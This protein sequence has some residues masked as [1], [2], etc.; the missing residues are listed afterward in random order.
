MLFYDGSE[1]EGR[2]HFKRLFDIGTHCVGLERGW[3]TDLTRQQGLHLIVRRQP[4]MTRSMGSWC[5]EWSFSPLSLLMHILRPKSSLLADATTK[6]RSHA[7]SPQ[8][9]LR[10]SSSR[11]SMSSTHPED[12]VSWPSSTRGRNMPYTS[13]TTKIPPSVTTCTRSSSSSRSTWTI[14]R[15]IRKWPGRGHGNC[16]G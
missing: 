12:R 8:P 6:N 7:R 2:A 11:K 1:E 5:D 10:T 13:I 14:P 3:S 15:T 9:R 4:H 16:T